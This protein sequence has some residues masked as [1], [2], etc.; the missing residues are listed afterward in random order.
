MTLIPFIPN[1]QTSPPFTA[2]VTLDGNGYALQVF[3]NNYAQRWYMSLTDNSGNLVINQ[4]LISSPPGGN[5][6]LA[7]GIF[8]T[9]TLV[10]REATQN[11]EVTP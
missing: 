6:Y 11:F 1:P 4:P 10:F 5:I 8:K 7:P 2:L 9:S 3:A